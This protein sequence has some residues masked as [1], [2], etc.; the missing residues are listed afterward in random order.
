MPS[1][2]LSRATGSSA[3]TAAGISC[4]GIAAICS[5]SKRTCATPIVDA[6]GPADWALPYWNYFKSGPE[7]A[8]AGI[9][10][11][12]LAGRGGRQ[13]A[14]RRRSA[15]GR[16]TTARSSSRSDQIDLNAL[17]RSRVHRR[18]QGGSPGFGGVDTGFTHGGGMH[19]GIETQPH[20]MVHGLVGGG[21]EQ[22][23]SV[24]RSDVRSRYSAGLDPIFWLHHANIDRLWEV[25][26]KS[27]PS[28]TDPTDNEMGEGTGE[29]R[30]ARV[31]HA[32]AGWSATGPTRPRIRR[33]SRHWAIPTTIFRRR[34]LPQIASRRQ[35]L[36][37]GMAPAEPP[38][39]AAM[40]E[41]VELLGAEQG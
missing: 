7:P 33:A 34:R 39:R 27:S 1:E 32:D 25:W 28:H 6:G 2:A 16:T 22:R 31:R 40:A 11:A 37:L 35:R 10:L 12:G 15:T 5:R 14:L 18:R 38:G 8:A 30:P 9:R 17:E 19:G 36:G 23:P 4:P 20:D 21:D 41:H 24:P 29:H 26:N 3:S 13:P